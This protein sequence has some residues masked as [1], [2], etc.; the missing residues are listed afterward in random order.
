MRSTF[1][2]C[3]YRKK[4]LFGGVVSWV[5]QPMYLSGYGLI[6][7]PSYSEESTFKIYISPR[8]LVCE[9]G[10]L[11]SNAFCPASMDMSTLTTVVT[12]HQNFLSCTRRNRL[13]QGEQGTWK[14]RCLCFSPRSAQYSTLCI[15]IL[16]PSESACR[17]VL[18]PT[19]DLRPAGQPTHGQVRTRLACVRPS[20]R[21]P[22][23]ASTRTHA[24][25]H[26]HACTPSHACT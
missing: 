5:P 3:G 15:D 26:S 4:N 19:S 1:G 7:A 24:R 12:V 21:V 9:R 18:P 14:R 23:H 25:A 16:K 13:Q 17:F 22:P 11:V 6:N 8:A 20:T 2:R 10:T